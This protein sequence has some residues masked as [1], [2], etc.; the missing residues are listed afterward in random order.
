[1][2]TDLRY[3]SRML[4]KSPGF[5]VIAIL[6]L[7][8]GIGANSAIFSVIDTVL[9]RPLPF[10]QPNELAMLWSTPNKGAARETHSFP[11]SKDFREQA[12]SFA[13]LAV[14]SQAGAVL[15]SGPDGRELNGLAAT[16]DIFQVLRVAPILGRAYTRAEDS[17]DSRVV[18]FTY[19]AWQR[20]FNG[21]PNI[22]REVRLSLKP[23]TVIG[24]MPRGFR[25]PLDAHAEYLMPVHP[26]ALRYCRT[27]ARISSG[28]WDDCDRA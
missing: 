1:M 22:G 26:F 5:S 13:A 2:L 7:A 14:Y 16:S 25:F 4:L 8:L 18:I 9:L 27:A 21:D 23:Y 28:R 11:D 17:P 20:Y 12:Q 3:A 19:D 15:N 10:P 24:V 6:T